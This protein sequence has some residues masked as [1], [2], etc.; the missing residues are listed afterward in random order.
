MSAAVDAIF[1]GGLSEPLSVQHARS[2]RRRP[3]LPALQ[4]R[5]LRAVWRACTTH[6]TYGG[7]GTPQ[8][9]A[10]TATGTQSVSF[11]VVQLC[12]VVR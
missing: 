4:E 3:V 8:P 7:C 5:M 9:A 2:A 6:G 10:C 11:V 1:G 12:I